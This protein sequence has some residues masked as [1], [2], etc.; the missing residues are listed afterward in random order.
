MLGMATS[1]CS[2]LTA[3][4]GIDMPILTVE[5]LHVHYGPV[6]AVRDV[7]LSIED[8]EIVALLGANGAGK[9]S[10]LNAI[11]MIAKSTM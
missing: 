4:D 6:E 2:V 8:G 3:E 5:G 1:C 7:S 9:S 11:V 10:T